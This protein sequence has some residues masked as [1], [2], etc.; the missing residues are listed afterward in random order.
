MQRNIAHDALAMVE[1]GASGAALLLCDQEAARERL[2][3]AIEQAGY[4]L[5]AADAL[6]A[7]VERLNQQVGIDLV[8]IDADRDCGDELD[9]LL[10]RANGDAL[11]GRYGCVVNSPPA[12]IDIVQARIGAERLHHVCEPEPGQLVE[13]LAQ[14]G[15][16]DPARLH[17][18]GRSASKLQQLSEEAGRIANALAAMSEDEAA[19]PAAK[20]G[21]GAG[22]IDVAKVRAMIRARRLRDQYFQSELF[23]DPAWDMLLDLMAARLEGQRVAVSSLCIAAAVPAT[24]ALRWI[25]TLTDHGLFVR[26]A[27]PQD[28]RRVYIELS[29]KAAAALESYLRAVQRLSP[30]AV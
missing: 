20:A 25:K 17:D 23:A 24:T 28:G 9:R 29:E 6:G 7:G 14:A 27:D 30:L 18:V 5:S 11:A 4:R 1:Y 26:V 2:R 13:T 15:K 19:S 21:N 8:V 10:N 22:D 3:M 12:L 16:R